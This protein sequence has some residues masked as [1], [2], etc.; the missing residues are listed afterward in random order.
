[1][2]MVNKMD[3]HTLAGFPRGN[4]RRVLAFTAVAVLRF[5]SPGLIV[6]PVARSILAY[7]VHVAIPLALRGK[8]R[9]AP[10]TD[11]RRTCVR[12][13][14]AVGVTLESTEIICNKDDICGRTRVGCPPLRR[15]E[16]ATRDHLEM[17]C[18][19]AT[20]TLYE[21]IRSYRCS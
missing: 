9:R 6:S 12:R 17:V 16:S 19:W 15:Y 14:L 13:L 18:E 20:V 1:M 3:Y 5:C 4:G 7:C 10:Y 2:V 8:A 21:R 11:G